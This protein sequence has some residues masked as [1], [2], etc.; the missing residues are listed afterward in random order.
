MEK[1]CPKCKLFKSTSDFY[2]DKNR[3]DGLYFYCKQCHNLKVKKYHQS[4]KGKVALKTAR[5]KHAQSDKGKVTLK[6]YAQSDK[7]KAAKKKYA[8][9]DKGKATFKRANLFRGFAFFA[10]L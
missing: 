3:K 5:K 2:K 8:Q 1:Q 4:D 7:G 6:K 10:F 9:S